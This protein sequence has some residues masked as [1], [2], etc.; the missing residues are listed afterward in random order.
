MLL[1]NPT[2]DSMYGYCTS[3][4]EHGQTIFGRWVFAKNNGPNEQVSARLLRAERY[5]EQSTIGAALGE[6]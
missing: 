2:A 3:Q 1:V 4:D 6:Q 5:L